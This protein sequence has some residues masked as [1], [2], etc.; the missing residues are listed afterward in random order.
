[1]K[2]TQHVRAN[3]TTDNLIVL[4]LVKGQIFT[5]NTI[6]SR[7]WRGLFLDNQPKEQLVQDIAKEWGTTPEVVSKDVE[8]FVVQLRQQGLVAES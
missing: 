8:R 7:I 4:D 6:G 1:M 3:V 5:A 2:P